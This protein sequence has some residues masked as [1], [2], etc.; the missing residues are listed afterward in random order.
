MCCVR[1]RVLSCLL[2]VI[3]AGERRPRKEGDDSG[4]SVNSGGRDANLT[5][6]LDFACLLYVNRISLTLCRPTMRLQAIAVFT[7]VYINVDKNTSTLQSPAHPE[8]SPLPH[9]SPAPPTPRCPAQPAS[10]DARTRSGPACVAD[11]Y[12]FACLDNCKIEQ[13]VKCAA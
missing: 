7:A 13:P 2:I 3:R 11:V 1:Y 9:A 6:L 8:A 4:R 10:H 5:L 12:W